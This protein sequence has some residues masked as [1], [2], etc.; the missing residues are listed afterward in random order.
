MNLNKW[1]TK[2]Y[3]WQGKS[4]S[5]NFASHAGVSIEVIIIIIIIISFLHAF[6]TSRY[7]SRK[8]ENN[9][10]VNKTLID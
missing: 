1:R 3:E 6:Y 5:L 10:S 9:F 4:V 8:E 7:L 2:E